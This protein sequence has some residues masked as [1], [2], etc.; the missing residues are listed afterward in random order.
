MCGGGFDQRRK[1]RCEVKFLPS[2]GVAC[3]LR[4]K[5]VDESVDEVMEQ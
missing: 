1:T 3:A 4:G 2:V 5:Q